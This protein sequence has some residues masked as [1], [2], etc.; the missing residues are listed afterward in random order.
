MSWDFP[1]AQVLLCRKL[2]SL[3]RL[4]E[5]RFWLCCHIVE[6]LSLFHLIGSEAGGNSGLDS[7]DEA[8]IIVMDRMS[9]RLRSK[10]MTKNFFHSFFLISL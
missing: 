7:L 10:E 5:L 1:Y 8:V 4:P 3:K 2:I 6:P 9:L